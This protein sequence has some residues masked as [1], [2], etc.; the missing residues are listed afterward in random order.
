[1]RLNRE[2]NRAN[3]ELNR[4]RGNFRFAQA[5]PRRGAA[6]PAGNGKLAVAVLGFFSV[7]NRF[8]FVE[9]KVAAA[10]L[11][12]DLGS[13]APRVAGLSFRSPRGALP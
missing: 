12:I 13:S 6:A 5:P 1:M 10:H 3:R 11:E 8:A 9:G 2:V 4:P 7:T